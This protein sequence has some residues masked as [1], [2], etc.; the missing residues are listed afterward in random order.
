MEPKLRDKV[1]KLG[2]LAIK[3]TALGFAGVPDRIIL[4]PGGRIWFVEMK[5]EGRIKKEGR[6][7]VVQKLIQSLGFSVWVIDT[8][9]LLQEFLNEIQK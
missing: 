4:M 5:T 2:G 1:K 9:I 3:F 6:Q 7:S 8:E